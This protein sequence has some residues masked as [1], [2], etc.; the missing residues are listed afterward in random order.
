[1]LVLVKTVNF[2]LTTFSFF[3]RI[4]TAFV[5]KHNSILLLQQLLIHSAKYAPKDYAFVLSVPLC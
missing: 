4:I 2:T 3:F 5:I 1:M